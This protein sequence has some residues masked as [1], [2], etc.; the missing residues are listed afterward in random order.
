MAGKAD[1]SNFNHRSTRTSK[2]DNAHHD[3][4]RSELGQTQGAHV[5]LWYIPG[6]G[7]SCKGTPL[8]PR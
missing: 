6:P 3:H 5:A 2:E 7:N 8:G 1:W 4:S